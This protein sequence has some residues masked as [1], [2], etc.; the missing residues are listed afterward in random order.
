M[1]RNSSV[2]GLSPATGAPALWRAL[3]PEITL[4]WT[5]RH[6]Q[7]S[8]SSPGR[9]VGYQVR[10][11]GFESQSRRSDSH[12]SSMSTQLGLLRP[13][14]SKGGEESNGKLP[15][16]CRMHR[17]QDFLTPSSKVVRVEK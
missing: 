7:K 13:G 12:C 10:G 15:H 5:H 4:L 9:A 1:C 8:C 16:K 11:P 17:S 6:H 2:A 3:K 14:K